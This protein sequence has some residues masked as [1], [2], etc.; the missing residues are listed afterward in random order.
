MRSMT[1]HIKRNMWSKYMSACNVFYY[2]VIIRFL[3]YIHIYI[4]FLS[5]SKKPLN[6]LSTS[7]KYTFYTSVR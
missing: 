6:I 4:F 3:K 1:L 7:S 5:V 2:S